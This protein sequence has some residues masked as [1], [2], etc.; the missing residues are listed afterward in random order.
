MTRDDH[1]AEALALY[2]AA[3]RSGERTRLLAHPERLAL[4]AEAQL[5]ATLALTAPTTTTTTP[6]KRTATKKVA[7]SKETSK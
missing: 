3:E 7:E 4:L 1:R 6:R 5:H 2:A